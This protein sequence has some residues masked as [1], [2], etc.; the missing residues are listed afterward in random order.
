MPRWF[1]L[2]TKGTFLFREW[3]TDNILG[4]VAA[5]V[6]AVTLSLIYECASFVQIKLRSPHQTTK[7]RDNSRQAKIHIFASVLRTFSLA[8]S[9]IAML[10]A[11]SFNVWILIAIVVGSGIGYLIGRPLVV[12]CLQ[13]TKNEEQ[14]TQANTELLHD[15][16]PV[17]NDVKYSERNNDKGDEF[18]SRV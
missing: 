3:R 18:Q 12:T 16:E 5:L 7:R 11:M 9:Y 10:C 1:M 17:S 14:K 2:Y 8:T 6:L 4:L 13:K 15:F